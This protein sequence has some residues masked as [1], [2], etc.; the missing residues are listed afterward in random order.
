[1]RDLATTARRTVALVWRT[2]PRL[3]LSIFGLALVLGAIPAAIAWVGKRIVDGVVQVFVEPERA[4]PETVVWW[5]LLELGLVAIQAAASRAQW[6]SEALLRTELGEKVNVA[7]LEKA[8]EL[9]LPDFENPDLADRM[10]RARRGASYRPLKFATGIV[11]VAQS[12]IA[13]V[14]YGFLLWQLAP[15]ALLLV[16]LAAVPAFIVES[17]FSRD[18]FRLFR[19]RAPESRRQNYYEWLVANPETAKEV[20]LFG[21]GPVFVDRYRAIFDAHYAEDRARTVKQAVW[22]YGLGLLS[23][24]VFYGTYAWIAVRTAKGEISFGDM[25]MY[26]LVF[27]NAQGAFSNVLAHIRGDYEDLLYVAELFT[28]LDAKTSLPHAGTATSGPR[29][30]DGIRF[31][32]VTFSYPKAKEP[33]L[34]GVDIHIPPGHKLALVGENGAGK[35]TLIKLMTGLY[36]P[37]SG[38][39]TLDGLDLEAWDPGALRRRIGVIFQDFVQYQL[40]AGENVGVG[41]VEALDDEERWQRA[42]KK[43]LAHDVIAALPK[44]Y[45]T[46]LGDWFDEGRELSVGQWQKIA[47]ARAFMREKADILVLDEPTASMDAAA[48]MQIFE[49]FRVLAEDRMAIIISHR[50]STV[51]IADVI[52]V[53]HEG[54]IVE[55]GSHRE[56]LELGGRYARLFHM[57]A[58]GYR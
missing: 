17:R 31:E 13:L 39:I 4:D 57:Q 29:P 27:R 54:K 6:L 16:A 15:W 46:Q 44:G 48:E 25:T 3:A 58:Q 28:L 37:T 14:S 1:L 20:K 18:A 8:L 23:L 41:D 24:V 53:L 43:G 10:L 7:I 11:D 32:E 38:R 9:E 33:V 42:A 34:R 21:L 40:I 49:R 2:N 52:A 51:R 5:V 50:F 56:L 36:R 12:S 55:R 19:W 45:H 47:L 22:G 30:D 35:T 26:L